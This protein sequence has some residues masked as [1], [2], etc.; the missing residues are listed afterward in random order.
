M[1]TTAEI[2]NRTNLINGT[3]QMVELTACRSCSGRCINC[4][5]HQ[6]WDDYKAWCKRYQEWIHNPQ[7]EK[8]CYTT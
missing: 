7:A 5:Y 1:K 4:R 6:T 3:D 8:D 2:K